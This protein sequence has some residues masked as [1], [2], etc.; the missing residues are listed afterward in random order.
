MKTP[1]NKDELDELKMMELKLFIIE[2]NKASQLDRS[3]SKSGVSSETKILFRKEL[4]RLTLKLFAKV[5]SKTLLNKDIRDAILELKNLDKKISFGQAQKVI[6]VALK[7]YCFIK[8]VDDEILE[9]LDCPLDSLSMKGQGIKNSKMI[10][11][12][13]ED[14][15]QYQDKFREDGTLRI[16]RDKVYDK[17]RVNAF[18][19]ESTDQENQNNP[20]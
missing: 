13:M 3:F 4:L 17:Q 12:E 1:Y 18:L 10:N 19:G 8:G 2:F 15:I 20:E 5:D 16:L 14:Y 11:V 7:Q 6:N 9:E